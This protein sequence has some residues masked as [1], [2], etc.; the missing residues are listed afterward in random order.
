VKAMAEVLFWASV[1]MM[2]YVYLGFQVLLTLLVKLNGPRRAPETANA[3]PAEKWP[4]VTI[5]VAA[6]NEEAVIA[7]RIENLLNLRYPE[8]AVEIMVASDGSADDT[9]A[10]A[11]AYQ[12]RGVKVIEFKENRGKAASHNAAA[13]AAAGEVLV[14][15]DAETIFDPNFLTE[16]VGFFA[17]ARYGCG[18]GELSFQ[19][20]NGLGE[21][22]S[23]FW[24]ME[25]RKMSLEHRLGVLPFAAGACLLIRKSLYS[26]I[27][28]Y[29]DVDDC[30]P[31]R[32][33]RDGYSVFYATTAKAYDVTVRTGHAHYQ[34]RVRTAVRGAQALLD[35]LPGM[36]RA[37]ALR[38]AFIVVSHRFLRWGG[39]YMMLC[40]FIA[41][42]SLTNSG[43][44]LYEITFIIQIAF[45]A[46]GAAG[47]IGEMRAKNGVLRA[48]LFAAAYSFIAANIA[49]IVATIRVLRGDQ[50]VRWQ[51]IGHIIR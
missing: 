26:A 40:A 43:S 39:G 32:V 31:Y 38:E 45:Y 24:R 1:A 18:S 7:Q 47:W 16:A 15:T 3:S 49:F 34:K 21:S 10:R 14:F 8:G 17:D 37:G 27:P 28:L 25:G 46:L 4:P 13:Q 44:T 11:L 29:L 22:E 6:H 9:V 51:P 41:N 12:D 33:V 35:E 2:V 23:F 19:P 48:R 36:I 50:I 5:V 20:L 42:M 30:L